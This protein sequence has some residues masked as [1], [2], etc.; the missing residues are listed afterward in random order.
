MPILLLLLLSC[1]TRKLNSS[2]EELT[3]FYDW[4]RSVNLTGII[5]SIKGKNLY[6][7][8]D[9]LLTL[10]EPISVIAKPHDAFPDPIEKDV[11]IIELQMPSSQKFDLIKNKKVNVTGS[12]QNGRK[13]EFSTAVVMNVDKIEDFSWSQVKQQQFFYE[14]EVVTLLGKL[15]LETFPGRPNY[16]DVRQGDETETCWIL[17]LEGPISVSAK[18]PQDDFNEVE[19]GVHWLQLVMDYKTIVPKKTGFKVNKNVKVTGTLYHAF[20][21]HHH[22]RVLLTVQRVEII[23]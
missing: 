20:S 19:T 17:N 18:T 10:N 21:G 2:K 3:Y 8:E 9:F 6:Q 22:T 5:S 7:K 16:E 4:E 13:T 15:S 1:S 23:E 14:P 12:L 11:R